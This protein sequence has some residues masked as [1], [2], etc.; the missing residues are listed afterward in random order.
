MIGGINPAGF[1]LNWCYGVEFFNDTD[2]AGQSE[3]KLFMSYQEA[4]MQLPFARMMHESCIVRKSNGQIKMLAIGGKVGVDQI[5]SGFTDSVISYDMK[6]VFDPYLKKKIDP[7]DKIDVVWE[8][9]KNMN[10]AR[11]NFALAVLDN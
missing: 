2:V 3:I 8:T 6:Y 7:E 10:N 11:A 9:N 1:L 5:T 4:S